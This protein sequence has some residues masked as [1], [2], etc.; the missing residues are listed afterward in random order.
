MGASR[1][2]TGPNRPTF[3]VR[4]AALAEEG[5]QHVTADVPRCVE[6]ADIPDAASSTAA[7]GAV[8]HS[9]RTTPAPRQGPS[10]SNATAPDP[11]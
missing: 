10:A 4:G 1:A 6:P 7:S 8:D 3:G 5:V 9:A 2:A 11:S